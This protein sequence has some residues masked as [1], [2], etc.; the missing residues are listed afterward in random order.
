[1]AGFRQV[2]V[3]K[4]IVFRGGALAGANVQG[5]MITALKI[6]DS[7]FVADAS[8]S[9]WVSTTG[10]N[11]LTLSHTAA[12]GGAEL[13]TLGATAEDC[14]EFYHT[15]QWSAASN[16]GGLFKVQISRITNV[17]VCC[18]F[19]D[20][21]EN[22]DDHI[23]MEVDS[24]ALR[25]ASNTADFCGMVFDT[26]A[27][28]DVWYCGASEDGTE[29][30]PVAATGALAPVANT[31]F[32]VKVQT[33]T[34]GNVTFWYGTSIDRLTAVGYL[35]DAIAAASTDLLTPYVGLLSHAAS[36]ATATISRIVV[37]QDN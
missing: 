37:W 1:M 12:D 5:P 14:G 26:D 22:T 24:A 35:P 19:V 32:Y 11:G 31:Y 13:M 2:N 36:A 23:A 20:A 33:D 29:G 21:Y 4:E 30:T 34:S 3:G 7:T 28:T 9:D 15:A 18:G 17:A 16:V 10:S 27:T 25:A 8:E 6:F